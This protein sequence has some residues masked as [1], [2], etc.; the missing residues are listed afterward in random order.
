MKIQEAVLALSQSEKLKAGLIWTSQALA[1]LAGLPETERAGAERIVQ[2]LANLLIHE[3]R[4][5]ENVAGEGPW[6][7][8]EKHLDRAVVMI[9]SGVAPEAVSHLTQALSRVTDVGQ[10]AMTLLQREG[11]L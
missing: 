4:L 3:V 7:E 11:V 10:R 5:A 1:I 6:Q 9:S 2:V 8:I